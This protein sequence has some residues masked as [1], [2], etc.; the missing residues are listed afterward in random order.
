MLMAYATLKSKEETVLYILH[1]TLELY[2]IN[3]VRGGEGE[4]LSV[5]LFTPHQDGAHWMEEQLNRPVD[6]RYE[7][8]TQSI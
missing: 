3:L 8:A 5:S 7:Y 2:G 4:L 1:P 6:L